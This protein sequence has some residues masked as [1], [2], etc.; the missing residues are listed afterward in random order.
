MNMLKTEKK[1]AVIS[2]LIEGC[3]IRSTERMTGVHRDTIM[4]LLLSVG[5]KCSRVLSETMH[6][7]PCS[8]VQVDEIWTFVAKKQRKVRQGESD[9]EIGDQYVFV[10][11]DADSKLVPSF[12]VGKRDGQT[13]LALMTDLSRRVARRLQLT[14]DGFSAYIDS[15]E[16]AF[17]TDVDYPMLIKQFGPEDPGRARYSPP[18]VIG[19]TQVI[20]NGQPR[21]ADISTSYVERQNLTI[22]MM[23]RRFTRL[24][25]AFSKKLANLKAALALHFAYYNLCRVHQTL[26]VTPA[27]AAGVTNRVWGLEELL[28]EN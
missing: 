25:N 1:L 4:R 28:S 27:M 15:T 17:G 11:L 22:R 8:R 24:T 26:R 6:D 16:E 12:E 13:A 5:E 23:C 14:T 21:E 19:V 9:Q 7:L 2:A 20:F 18:T 3:S 10:A